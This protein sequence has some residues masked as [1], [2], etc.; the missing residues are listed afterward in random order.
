MDFRPRGCQ[1]RH[2]GGDGNRQYLVLGLGHAI[3]TA[4][5]DDAVPMDRVRLEQF[6]GNVNGIR[7]PSTALI[8]GPCTRPMNPPQLRP[9]TGS[10]LVCHLLGDEVKDLAV[11]ATVDLISPCCETLTLSVTRS[12]GC[13]TISSPCERPETTSALRVFRCPSGS[14]RYVRAGFVT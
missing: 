8:V 14:P 13:R 6:V 5:Q 2:A 7:S 12:L 11:P 3:H 10:K 4:W 1:R 9:Q